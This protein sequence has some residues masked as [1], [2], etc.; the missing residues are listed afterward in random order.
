[1]RFAY[2][3][4]LKWRQSKARD[5]LIFSDE[6][7]AQIKVTNDYEEPLMEARRKALSF[8]MEKLNSDDRRVIELR[9]S[10]HG[11][12]KEEAEKTG[13]KMHKLYYAIERIRM[14][15]FNCI[16]LN[17]KNNGLNDA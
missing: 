10:R 3:Q 13:I 16:E 15:L 2:L 5:K 7:L 17:L 12:I 1:M 11:A 14:Q 9:Y 4:V 6:L 8:C